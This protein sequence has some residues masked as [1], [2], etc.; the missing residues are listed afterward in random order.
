MAKPFFNMLNPLRFTSLLLLSAT[1]VLLFSCGKGD[2]PTVI[3]GRVTDKKT[4]EPIEGAAIDIDFQTERTESGSMKTDHD[5]VGLSTDAQGEFQ[6][7]YEADYTRTYSELYKKSYGVY[8]PLKIIKGRVSN[9][10]IKLAPID[11]VLKLE[12]ENQ[13]GQYNSIYV[14]IENPSFIASRGFL[15]MVFTD[16]FPVPLPITGKHIE[17]FSLPSEEF[18]KIHW[19]FSYFTSSSGSSFKDSVFLS[20]NDTAIYKLAY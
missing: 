11:G 19:G 12:L 10:D 1:S 2:S 8:G 6:Y 20:L 14:I 13:S 15:G 17:Y 16:V 5:Y 18:T 7:T 4:G 9:L 3:N